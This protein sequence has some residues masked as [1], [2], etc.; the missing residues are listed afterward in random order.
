MPWLQGIATSSDCKVASCAARALLHVESAAALQRHLVVRPWEIRVRRWPALLP[1]QEPDAGG[2][3]L[4]GQGWM[5]VDVGVALAGAAA[6]AG[7]RCRWV[8]AGRERVGGGFAN[9]GGC[10]GVRAED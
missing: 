2:C 5:G 9:K 1:E 8:W 6:R 3:G 4:G 10:G 7:A